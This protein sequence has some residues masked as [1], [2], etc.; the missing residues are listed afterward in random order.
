MAYL[1]FLSYI[2][3]FGPRNDD[4]SRRASALAHVDARKV[5][6]VGICH[7]PFEKQRDRHRETDQNHDAAHEFLPHTARDPRPAVT[8]DDRARSH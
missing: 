4:Q 2:F 1:I 8:A 3:L 5:S 6:E 7:L